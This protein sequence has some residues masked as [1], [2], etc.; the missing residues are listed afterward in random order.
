MECP[1]AVR[2]A[3]RGAKRF[4]THYQYR[5][6]SVSTN[7]AVAVRRSASC[8]YISLPYAVVHMFRHLLGSWNVAFF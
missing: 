8:E 4:F 3:R 1:A 7:V 5:Q 6:E 2:P